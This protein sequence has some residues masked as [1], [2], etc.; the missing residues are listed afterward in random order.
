VKYARPRTWRRLIKTKTKFA[1][2]PRGSVAVA[3]RTKNLL[4]QDT[5]TALADVRRL[6]ATHDIPSSPGAH[7][8]AHRR[9]NM[10]FHV[11]SARVW[12]HQQ[13]ENGNTGS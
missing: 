1:A 4:L 5:A 13:T 11:I 9:V 2:V 10:I 7:R 3:D 8:G 12:L 6:V